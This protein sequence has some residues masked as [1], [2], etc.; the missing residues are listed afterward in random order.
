MY[1][2]IVCKVYTIGS[3]DVLKKY[4]LAFSPHG[5]KIEKSIKPAIR[6][7]TLLHNIGV[8]RPDVKYGKNTKYHPAP[9]ICPVN[10]RVHSSAYGR[11]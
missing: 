11:Q 10:G 6:T 8:T 2:H 7:Y 4:Y 1:V 3:I 9:Q 5:M